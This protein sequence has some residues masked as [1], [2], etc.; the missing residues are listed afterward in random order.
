MA[1][2]IDSTNHSWKPRLVR[3]LYPYPTDTEVLNL[4]ISRTSTG[5]DKLIWKYS[6]SRDYQVK[7]DYNLISKEDIPP[8]LNLWQLIW[9]VQV[10]FKV[11]N[12]VWRL[13]HDSL[14]TFL[15]SKNRGIPVSS[16]CPFYD[17]EDESSSHLLLFCPFARATWHGT[18]LDVHTFD[19][20]NILVQRWI[21]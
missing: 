6:S 16:S 18:S 17:E 7:K 10:P 13:C 8:N 19:L 2:L 9:K 14:P 12:F 5:S 15:T 3:S 4:P 21:R 1:N 11:G 20:R